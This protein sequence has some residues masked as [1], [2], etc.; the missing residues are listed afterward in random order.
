M[1]ILICICSKS[2]NPLLYKCIDALYNIQIK[3]ESNYKICVVD[4]DSDDLTYYKQIEESFPNV[5]II[6]AKN[7]NYEYGA[8]KYI[9]NKYP[10]YDT[11]FC[12]QDSIII[13]TYIDLNKLDNNTVYTA[14]H[15][16]GFNS[17]GNAVKI[18]GKK[19]LNESNIDPSL[20][21]S[22]IDTNFNMAQ[23]CIFIVTN[24]IMHDI[25]KT[26]LILPSDKISSRMYE[27]VFG[28]YFIIKN[29]NTLDLGL[30]VHKHHG[31]RG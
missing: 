2:P 27:R 21:E 30:F 12:I 5:E 3:N 17:D 13:H 16:S 14:H 31:L 9:L 4:S 24:N 25:L 8:W 10:E 20:Y 19:N 15:H 1:Q 26:F 29:I 22:I 6:F 18:L 7:K 11:Y 28:L 23:H